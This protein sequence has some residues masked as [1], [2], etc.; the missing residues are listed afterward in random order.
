[1]NDTSSVMFNTGQ[2]FFNAKSNGFQF[3]KHQNENTPQVIKNKALPPIQ[4][5]P[6]TIFGKPLHSV[7]SPKRQSDQIKPKA[8]SHAEQQYVEKVISRD[9]NG[10]M[11]IDIKDYT[12]D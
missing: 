7:Q 5:Q 9:Q 4:N 11:D 3:R 12:E 8:G 1:M 10:K 2:A 6:R